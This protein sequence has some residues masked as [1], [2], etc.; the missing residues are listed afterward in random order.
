MSEPTAPDRRRPGPPEPCPSIAGSYGFA[1]SSTSSSDF[2]SQ[3]DASGCSQKREHGWWT[4]RRAR[5][6]EPCGR[7]PKTPH[8]TQPSSQPRS[9]RS[10]FA[11]ANQSQP[12]RH[13]RTS[14]EST[15]TPRPAEA[16][17][18][19]LPSTRPWARLHSPRCFGPRIGRPT[20]PLPRSLPTAMRS[21]I[22]GGVACAVD[23]RSQSPSDGVTEDVVGVVAM[24]GAAGMPVGARYRLGAV[25]SAAPPG[26]WAAPRGRDAAPG[27]GDRRFVGAF[28]PCPITS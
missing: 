27:C 24:T 4:S 1:P 16:Q 9:G 3:H 17:R 22:P 15:R 10:R 7:S 23:P 28:M 25:G 6:R 5:H 11:R 13:Q 12:V 14:L 8:P 18:P 26:R 21:P 2:P 19:G 20:R